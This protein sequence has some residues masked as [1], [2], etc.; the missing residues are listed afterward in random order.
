[1]M[2]FRPIECRRRSLICTPMTNT[3]RDEKKRENK[4]K[5]KYPSRPKYS[6]T[7]PLL[8]KTTRATSTSQRTESSRAFLNNPERRLEKATWRLLL[9]SIRFSSTLPLGLMAKP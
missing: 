3:Q 4:K 9:S 6:K 7:L 2:R 5:F 1:M 8:E